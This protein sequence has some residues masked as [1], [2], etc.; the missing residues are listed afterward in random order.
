MK[1][2]PRDLRSNTAFTLRDKLA[3]MWDAKY[4]IP[5]ISC[6]NPILPF[7][8]LVISFNA[9]KWN[10]IWKTTDLPNTGKKPHNTIPA[11]S[12]ENGNL[13][14]CLQKKTTH[15]SIVKLSLN[16]ISDQVVPK[17]Q[18][19]FC[20]MKVIFN[21]YKICDSDWLSSIMHHP[22]NKTNVDIFV[23]WKVYLWFLFSIFMEVQS[24]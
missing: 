12:W 14:P 4:Y 10:I 5:H 16:V 22:G 9:K 19:L 11:I 21:I 15:F 13:S 23:F 24:K 8:S 18:S 6:K 1:N 17:T 2:E 7:Y 20:P 3:W